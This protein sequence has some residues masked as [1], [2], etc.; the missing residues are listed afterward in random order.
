MMI[1][2]LAEENADEQEDDLEE[3]E[4]NQLNEGE[5]LE[6]DLRNKISEIDSW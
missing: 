5:N 3:T 2:D 1:D 4:N 6:L